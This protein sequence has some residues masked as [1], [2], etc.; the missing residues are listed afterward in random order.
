MQS[1]IQQPVLEEC[2]EIV[3]GKSRKN[4]TFS[5]HVGSN[6]LLRECLGISI[7]GK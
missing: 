7:S 4:L 6:C 3:K 5:T 2:E 1:S